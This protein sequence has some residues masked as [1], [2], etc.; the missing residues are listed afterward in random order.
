MADDVAMTARKLIVPGILAFALLNLLVSLGVWQLNRKAWKQALIQQV[1]TRAKAAPLDLTEI[2]PPMR[3]A[4]NAPA[5]DFSR[6]RAAGSFDHS[7]E[8]HLIAPQ[9]QGAAWMIVTRFDMAEGPVLVM[10]GLVPDAMKD[11]A[12]RAAGQVEGAMTIE[13]RIRIGE[14]AGWFAPANDVERNVWFRRD[15]AGMQ[16]AAGFAPSTRTLPFMIELETPVPPGGLPKPQ[17]DAIN[18]RN[19]H[20]QYAITWFAL[21][22]V[23][24]VM[25][26]VWVRAQRR[27]G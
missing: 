1:E 5:L 27:R 4:A 13:G 10:R 17:L 14:P 21:A 24:I 25:F 19:D 8:I 3:D 6:V 20:L 23:L 7:R 11:P 22:G 18:L 2:T 9:R 12:R 15:L 16:V 26:G